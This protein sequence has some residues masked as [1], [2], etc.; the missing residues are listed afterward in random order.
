M[1]RTE[2]KRRSVEF[3]YLSVSFD[4]FQPKKVLFHIPEL[5]FDYYSYL[6]NICLLPQKELDESRPSTTF[7]ASTRKASAVMS[8]GLKEEASP[9]PMQETQALPIPRGGGRSP[10]SPDNTDKHTGPA[11]SLYHELSKVPLH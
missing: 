4:P 10:R 5:H 9:P 1:Y 11:G 3:P 2:W 8:L 6:K 7:F